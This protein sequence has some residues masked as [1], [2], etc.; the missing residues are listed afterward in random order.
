MSIPARHNDNDRAAELRPARGGES[1][2]VDAVS[3]GG[4]AT[5]WSWRAA[6]AIAVGAAVL[7][8]ALFGETAA[9]IVGK[10]QTSDTFAHGWLILPI[11]GWFVWNSRASLA[12]LSPAPSAWGLAAVAVFAFG[13]F[14]GAVADVLVVQQL[15]LAAMVQATVLAVLGPRV[16]L[17]LL[18]PLGYLYFAVPVGEFLVPPMQDW[19]AVFVVKTLRLVGVPVFSDGV[20]IAIPTGNFEVAEACAGVRFL[21]AMIALGVLWARIN[22]RSWPRRLL[23]VALSVAVPIVA[24]WLRAFG[25]VLVAYLT[26]NEVAVGV[27]HI[28][29]GW[30]FFVI[31]IGLL[32]A[33][34]MTFSEPHGKVV[35]GVE[36]PVFAAAGSRANVW[37]TAGMAVAALAIASSALGYDR[38][39]E[40]RSPKE[41][42]ALAGAARDL[43]MRS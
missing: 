35:S 41:L 43:I 31:V 15:A 26:D 24:N 34:G 9:S 32:F 17:V 8:L 27:D 11:C 13:W 38:Y 1:G 10:W 29:Y 14:L 18:F 19:T 25:I 22:Y 30:V 7:L 23:F 6:G 20:F 42:D 5:A 28:I 2:G 39:L 21:I 36:R 12:R 37:G 40:A 16:A 33:V 3:E 4:P